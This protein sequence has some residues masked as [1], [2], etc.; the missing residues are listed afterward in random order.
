MRRIIFY[1]ITFGLISV[2]VV[3][4]AFYFWPTRKKVFGYNPQ[5]YRSII[6]DENESHK[7]RIASV[8]KE[9]GM[10][11]HETAMAL[12][13]YADYIMLRELIWERAEPLLL[14]GIK[15]VENIQGENAPLLVKKLGLLADINYRIHG[16]YNLAAQYLERV[17]R[18][19]EGI[20]GKDD[21][22][23]YQYLSK[24]GIIYREE[25]VTQKQRLFLIKY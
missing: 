21:Y 25:K 13:D 19:Q 3:V 1:G 16:N 22:N 7:M 4:A 9:Y 23:L 10:N 14:R 6:H 15:I 5:L 2:F 24:L 11:S 8:E 18:I 17:V 20:T 12:F